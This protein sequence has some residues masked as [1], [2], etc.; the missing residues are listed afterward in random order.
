M[1]LSGPDCV[2]YSPV[3]PPTGASTSSDGALSVIRLKRSLNSPCDSDARCRLR[4]AI[5]IR[6]RFSRTSKPTQISQWR[7]SS[8]LTSTQCLFS[9]GDHC[10]RRP[11][12]N[13]ADTQTVTKDT[14]RL[15]NPR[16]NSNYK[17]KVIFSVSVVKW[18]KTWWPIDLVIFW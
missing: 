2:T 9:V 14:F 5:T 16:L 15:V 6:T 12:E 17:V 7:G 13:D 3:I 11:D 1:F 4:A 8:E 18:T 10:Q